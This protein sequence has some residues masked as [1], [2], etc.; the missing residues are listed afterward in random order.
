MSAKKERKVTII[1]IFSESRSLPAGR[2]RD[3]GPGAKVPF[4][5]NRIYIILICEFFDL[6]PGTKDQG[7]GTRDQGPG[8]NG[9]SFDR[10]DGQGPIF[11]KGQEGQEG[12]SSLPA[13]CAPKFESGKV[14][15][16]DEVT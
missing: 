6:G 8:T 5:A 3:Q 14:S 13:E 11:E 15:L 10:K 4:S 16:Y 9:Q 2:R 12:Y 7:P 1:V